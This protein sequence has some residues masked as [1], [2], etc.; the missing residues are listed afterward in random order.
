M[1]GDRTRPLWREPVLLAATVVLLVAVAAVATIAFEQIN[2]PVPQAPV[3]AA[4]VPTEQ[5]DGTSLPPV[6]PELHDAVDRPVVLVGVVDD[7]LGDLERCAGLAE[8]EF[9]PTVRSSVVTPEGLAVSV[10]GEEQGT[11]ALLQV[12]CFA[13]WDGRAWETWASWAAEAPDTEVAL[14]PPE[15]V[16]CRGDDAAVQGSER[17]APGGSA[18]LLQDRGPYWLAYPASGG[19]V[20]LA[21][22]SVDDSQD[23][24][25]PTTFLDT[26]GRPV[27][28]AAPVEGEPSVEGEPPAAGDG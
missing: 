10:R 1:A 15:P 18:W 23:G 22:W 19:Q 17:V 8:W 13:Q 14:G 4:G 26:R 24:P 6:P 9:A 2:P 11:E 5:P 12:T 27:E 3:D 21:V 25:P 28:D 20:V 16:C 7:P